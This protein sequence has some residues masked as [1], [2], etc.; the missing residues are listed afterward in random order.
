MT[1]VKLALFDLDHTL[2]DGDSDSLWGRFLV[3]QGAIDAEEYAAAHARYHADYLAGRLDVHEFLAFGLKPLRDNPPELLEAWRERFVQEYIRPRIP[4]ASRALLMHHAEHT[5]IIIT[6]TNSFITA[7]IAAELGVE[8]LIATVPEEAGGRFTGA[9]AGPPCFREGKVWKLEA[10]LASY[11]LTA[12]ERWFYSDSHNDLPLL[13][14]V[15]HPV[16]VNPDDVL[17]HEARERGWPIIRISLA[18]EKV[19]LPGAA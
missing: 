14:N 2:L 12:S 13:K 18:D 4:R 10:W 19:S 1:P 7:P 15:E 16:A 5:R 11:G 6:A 17:A 3:R 9:V 8:H